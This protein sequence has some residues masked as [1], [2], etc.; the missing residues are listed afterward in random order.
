MREVAAVVNEGEGI[1]QHHIRVRIKTPEM[2][3]DP[4]RTLLVSLERDYEDG[5]GDV[6]VIE[7][8]LGYG[9]YA[10]LLY[11]HCDEL[12]VDL[13]VQ[14]QYI[15]ANSEG[16]D[17]RFKTRRYRAILMEQDNPGMTDRSP[18]ASSREDLNATRTKNI[19]L[20]LIDEGLFQIRL[21]SVG[22]LY[23]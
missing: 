6:M 23:R 19:Q 22:R 7:T 16:K 10:Y 4:V 12:F 13:T 17:T 14:P 18:Q 11:P 9:D 3:L 8:T 1:R 21:A 2:W 20:Q 15:G 5:Y